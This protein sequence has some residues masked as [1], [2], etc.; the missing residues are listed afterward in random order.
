MTPLHNNII[1]K[2]LPVLENK[3]AGGIIL[4]KAPERLYEV[5]KCGPDVPVLKPGDTI[6]PFPY[7]QGVPIT[8]DKEKYEMFNVDQLDEFD[9]CQNTL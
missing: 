8:F 7:C 6:K 1:A 9:P 4:P 2:K 5:V 3:S